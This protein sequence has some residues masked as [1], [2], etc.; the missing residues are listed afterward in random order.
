[1]SF[2]GYN[3]ERKL[4]VG[5]TKRSET[6]LRGVNKG[7]IMP[8]SDSSSD[9]DEEEVEMPHA[10]GS[11]SGVNEGAAGASW[12]QRPLQVS[13]GMAAKNEANERAA[14]TGCRRQAADRT[15]Q[16]AAITN[17]LGEGTCLALT[18][19]KGT[20]QAAG[21]AT[22][23]SFLFAEYY[24]KR[25]RVG[26]GSDTLGD[27]L[28]KDITSVATTAQ[29]STSG[30]RP[31]SLKTPLRGWLVSQTGLHGGDHMMVSTACGVMTL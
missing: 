27:R 28:L 23:A 8:D 19:N 24:N 10:K 22:A 26:H 18:I 31:F 25:V 11:I 6:G 29:S 1:M 20:I 12:F 15:G 3:P 14:L 4:A 2:D 17:M 21:G 9:R 5:K 7:V 30:S 16:A 13:L